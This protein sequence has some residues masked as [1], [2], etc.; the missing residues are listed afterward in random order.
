VDCEI[1]LH[2][3]C[4]RAWV[5]TVYEEERMLVHTVILYLQSERDFV[6]KALGIEA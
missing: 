3:E 6:I 2:V 1:G 5:F 4:I